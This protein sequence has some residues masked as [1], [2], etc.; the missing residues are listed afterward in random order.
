MYVCVCESVFLCVCVL[1]RVLSQDS[2]P[3]LS[4]R[5]NSGRARERG[6]ERGREGWREGGREGWREGERDG[7]REGGSEGSLLVFHFVRNTSTSRYMSIN[8]HLC[9]CVCVRAW[10][11]VV[12]SVCLYQWNASPT[13]GIQY[14]YPCVCVCVCV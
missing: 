14:V 12:Q 8:K 13:L 10:D 9:V 6:M 2:R 5:H 3:T 4:C 7:E 11:T 1:Q